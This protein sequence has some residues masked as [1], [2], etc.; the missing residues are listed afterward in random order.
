MAIIVDAMFL[1]CQNFLPGMKR[2]RGGRIVNIS[3]SS[4]N[5]APAMGGPYVA[6]KAAV[7]GLTRTLASEVGKYGITVNA[8]APNPVPTPGAQVPLSSE[9]FDA[10]A[11]LQPIPRRL[12]IDDIVGVVEFLCGDEAAIITGQHLH[13]DGGMV[14][15]S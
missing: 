10:I 4:V 13:V 8:V 1:L 6:S 14:F 12:S 7:L 3:S 9:M 2:L 5:T 11:S 15:G